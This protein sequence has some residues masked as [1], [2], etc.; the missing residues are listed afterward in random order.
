MSYIRATKKARTT[1]IS[2]W[3]CDPLRNCLDRFRVSV[4]ITEKFPLLNMLQIDVFNSE[5]EK[6][7]LSR[8]P[9]KLANWSFRVFVLQRTTVNVHNLIANSIHLLFGDVFPV[10]SFCVRSLIYF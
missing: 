1:L 7:L 2:K 4:D 5:I 10:I 3:I 9:K 8:S 6:K